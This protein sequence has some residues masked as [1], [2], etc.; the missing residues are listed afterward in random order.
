MQSTSATSSAG[1]QSTAIQTSSL[2]NTDSESSDIQNDSDAGTTISQ[3]PEF[4]TYRRDPQQSS[5]SQL[6]QSSTSYEKLASTPTTTESL[7]DDSF[8][9]SPLTGPAAMAVR[10]E[11]NNAPLNPANAFSAYS[12]LSANDLAG[13]DDMRL[14]QL[15]RSVDSV[16]STLQTELA[17][18][19]PAQAE[20][21]GRTKTPFSTF[22]KLREDSP[23]DSNSHT[24]LGDIKDLSGL[25]VDIAPA[26]P[27][28]ADLYQAQERVKDVLGPDLVLKQDY[29][30][31]PNSWGYTGRIHSLLTEPGGLTHEVQ[32]G[33]PDITRFIDGKLT[34]SGGDQITL[35]DVTGY[36]G[37]IYGTSVPEPLQDQYSQQLSRITETN[38]TGQ[39]IADVPSVHDSINRY[40]EAVEATLPDRLNTP[41]APE[42]STRARIGN[43]L[44]R[45]LGP[46][47]I[48][49]GGF[50]AA[51]GAQAWSAGE[52]RVEAAVDVA[53]GTSSIVSGVAITT[54]RVALGT[55]TGGVVATL[56]G[57]RDIY[58]GI[59]D[60]DVEQTVVGSVKAG[61]G[62]AM[63]AG[64]ATANPV[65]IA[66]GAIAYG[67][68]VVYE[69][70]A[71]IASAARSA[72]GWLSGD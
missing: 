47:D 10:R 27:D 41:P 69:S 48:V 61:A 3:S 14:Q 15:S 38:R 63:L 66:G 39:S 67:G 1:N 18:A 37:D 36:K 44:G 60:G 71:A 25:R 29:I 43:N 17:E 22:G 12:G 46:I 8:N 54:G 53:A 7:S 6:A 2:N 70:R 40:T 51:N 52:D 5:T 55:T 19:L 57:A 58:T 4:D 30:Q 56:D 16:N 49:T 33:T 20:V 35:H 26:N 9:A 45:G 72:W 28:F 64:V 68:A 65:L 13:P 31:Q 24:L 23:V 50:Q 34:T 21:S 59:R 32:V 11:F 42:L 62:T